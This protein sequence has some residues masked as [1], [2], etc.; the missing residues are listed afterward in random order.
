MQPL[1]GKGRRKLRPL[2]AIRAGDERVAR[3]IAIPLTLDQRAELEAKAQ[4]QMR[5]V[6]SYVA[7]VIAESLRGS[8]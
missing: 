2:P 6:S 4:A 3:E 8:R 5:S 7:L 1:K